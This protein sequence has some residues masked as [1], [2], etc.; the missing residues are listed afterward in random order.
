MDIV[1]RKLTS[2]NFAAQ[3]YAPTVLEKELSDPL[4]QY[5]LLYHNSKAVGYI[6]FLFDHP[7]PG[8]PVSNL[9]LLERLYILNQYFPLKL[10][11]QLM[12]HLI[13]EARLHQQAGIWLNVWKEN[14]RAFAFYKKHGFKIFG[15][16][17]FRISPTHT[18]PNHQ[19][20]L[21]LE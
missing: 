9:T 18:N 16:Y 5:Y 8:S 3:T 17:D 11:G 12:A 15:S 6:K 13:E 7:Y 20:L 14:D 4:N 2:K 21:E 1:P 10:G 19:M